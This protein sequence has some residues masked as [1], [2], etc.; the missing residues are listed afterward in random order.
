MDNPPEI[1]QSLR[2]LMAEIG[3]KWSAATH[4]Q[5]M[6]EK[7]SEVLAGAPKRARVSRDLAY[8]AHPRQVLDAYQPLE[9]PLGPAL[10]FVHGG[11][12]TDGDKDRTPEVF[13]NVGYYLARH[14]VV[15]FNVEYRLA[16]EFTYPSGTEDIA[17]AVAWARANAGRFGADP[18][19]IFLM[20]HSAGGAHAAHYAYDRRFHPAGDPGIAGLIVA[21]G[22]VRAETLPDNPNAARVKAY[23]GD[24]ARM[25][26]GSGVNHVSPDSVPTLIA[27]AEFENPLL[28][29]HGAELFHRLAAA[30][31]RAPPIIR[32]AGHN[33]ASIV[34]HMNTAE[35]RLGREI[36]AF[37]GAT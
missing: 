14:G 3:P 24:A 26:E 4:M 11:A 17:A 10:L 29:V 8:A 12:F 19:R 15:C 1:P 27:L 2:G 6:G 5:L 22:R 21:S 28:D 16:P 25:E 35:D 32:M 36:L 37:I 23:Y 9:R 30:K 33:H 31:R 7:F 18:A 13:A 34:Y 20:G